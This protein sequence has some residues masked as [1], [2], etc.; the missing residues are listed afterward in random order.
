[1]SDN[2]IKNINNVNELQF[3]SNVFSVKI[4]STFLAYANYPNIAKF[5][6]GDN[7]SYCLWGD[8][9]TIDGIA[10]IDFVNFLK[11][12]SVFCT[13]ENSIILNLKPITFGEVL[14]KNLLGEPVDLTPFFSDDIDEIYSVLNNCN[15]IKDYENFKLDCSHKFRHALGNYS[16][17][18]KKC[19]ALSLYCLEKSAIITAVATEKTQRRQGFGKKVLLD[20][21]EKLKGREIFLLKEN[22]KNTIFYDK[23]NYKIIDK[24]CIGKLR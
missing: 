21:E 18:R 11:P 9:L 15:M 19:V 2:I 23:L 16:I 12:N 7:T 1:M 8:N 24:W 5:W 4:M 6:Q 22:E 14:H 20:L 3:N 13:Y 10:D 17:I